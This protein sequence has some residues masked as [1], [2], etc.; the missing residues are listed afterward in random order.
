LFVKVLGILPIIVEIGGKLRRK[1]EQ[2][3]GDH[4]ISS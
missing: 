4:D 1:E 2:R 3:L